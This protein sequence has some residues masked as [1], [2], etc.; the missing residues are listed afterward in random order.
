[1][2]RLALLA[3]LVNSKLFA[4]DIAVTGVVRT[5]DARPLGGVNVILKGTSRGTATDMGGNFTLLIP[6]GP[7]VLMFVFHQQRSVEQS[8]D[9][10]PGF[11]YQVNVIM[12]STS[13]TFHKSASA[14]GVLAH[15]APVIKGRVVNSDDIPLAGVRI[16]QDNSA[17]E[18]MT[19]SEGRF[20]LPLA[21][22]KN[23][24]TFRHPGSKELDFEILLAPGSIQVLE[25][26]LVSNRG[27]DR[28]RQSSV[29]PIHP[30][31]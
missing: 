25:V 27:R 30:E 22:G 4:V 29:K 26:F 19:D 2:F 17:F 23:I 16:T 12:A 8:L 7:A 11:Q 21:G 15:S 31:R 1:M 3:F 9:A 24:V 6:E 20:A 14:A 18:T 28:N 5:P 13:Q 10:Q